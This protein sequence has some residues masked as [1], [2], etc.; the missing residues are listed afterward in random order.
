MNELA[1]EGKQRTATLCIGILIF[2]VYGII[3]QNMVSTDIG[4]ITKIFQGIKLLLMLGL[5]AEVYKGKKWARILTVIVSIIGVFGS[6]S[7]YVFLDGSLIDK[8]PFLITAGL[9]LVA[10]YHF[11]FAKSYK[12]YC[13]HQNRYDD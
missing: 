11:G 8:L 4:L 7:G 3:Y 5:L 10:I 9:Y 2:I 6:V 1:K 13:T 12:A